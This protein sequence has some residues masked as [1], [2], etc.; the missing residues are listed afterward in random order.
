MLP[1]AAVLAAAAD[2]PLGW[3]SSHPI[4]SFAENFCNRGYKP[5]VCGWI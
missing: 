2:F 4:T 5:A 1:F 3:N